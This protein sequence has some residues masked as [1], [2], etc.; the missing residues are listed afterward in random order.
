MKR[1]AFTLVEMLTVIAI[2]SVLATLLLTG[3]A[4]AKAQAQASSCRNNLGQIA[5]ALALYTADFGEYPGTRDLP[6]QLP[7]GGADDWEDIWS[8]RL[9]PYVSAERSIFNCPMDPTPHVLSYYSLTNFSYGYN[10]YG[11]GIPPNTLNLGLGH[12]QA[13]G[14]EMPTPI[15]AV[16]EAQVIAPSD[17]IAIGDLN[18]IDSVF[19]VTIWPVS[20]A[21]YAGGPAARHN[22][23]ANMVFC[24]GH[25]EFGKQKSWIEE[26]DVARRRWNNDHEPHRET[27]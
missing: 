11:S 25:A 14:S 2:I 22:G 24:D 4:S 9:L 8:Y 23:G 10:A 7:P 27:W 21:P 16:T 17:M 15:L 5:K 6:S 13:P 26:T 20:V 3:L 18:D 12:V 19:T 1:Q